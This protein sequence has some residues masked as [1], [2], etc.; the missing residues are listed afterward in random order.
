MQASVHALLWHHLVV[1]ARYSAQQNGKCSIVIQKPHFVVLLD[2]Y[3][4][5]VR[6][7]FGIKSV[8][9]AQ[10]YILPNF[11]TQLTGSLILHGLK[12]RYSVVGDFKNFF[13]GVNFSWLSHWAY[14]IHTILQQH[15][16]CSQNW[17][18]ILCDMS[19]GL[20]CLKFTPP[21]W[22]CMIILPQEGLCMIRKKAI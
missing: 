11:L 10:H 15:L 22:R 4:C 13:K 5:F 16:W 18:W 2:C 17:W 21:L 1:W 20:S 6:I 7:D 19:S 9:E 14:K 12:N 3:F 8:P